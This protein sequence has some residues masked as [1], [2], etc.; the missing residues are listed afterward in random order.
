LLI[1]NHRCYHYIVGVRYKSLLKKCLL[2]D[3]AGHGDCSCLFCYMT[4]LVLK[5]MY[6]TIIYW[7]NSKMTCATSGR[8][9]G[10][11]FGALKSP[12]FSDVRVVQPLVFLLV[13]CRLLFFCPFFFW[14]LYCL[15]LDLRVIVLSVLR[16]KGHCIVCP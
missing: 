4:S 8:W 1:M 15:S 5:V 11:P 14:P 13:F 10:Y 7:F 6:N 2:I 3:S 9:T 16:L 12:S